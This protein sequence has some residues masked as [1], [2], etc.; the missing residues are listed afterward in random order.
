MCGAG[1]IAI[2]NDETELVV[3]GFLKRQSVFDEPAVQWL[4]HTYAWALENFDAQV[5]YHESVLVEP[6]NRYFPGRA[7]SVPAMAGLVF[8]KV[9]EYAGMAHW[10]WQLLDQATCSLP[11]TGVIPIHGALRGSGGRVSEQTGA[12]I[13][14]AYNP[15]QVGEPDALIATFA[16]GLAQHL[17]TQAGSP[18]PGGV[19]MWPQAT[20][21]LAVFMGF[22]L[23]FANSAFNHRGGCGSCYNSAAQRQANLSEREATY[24][25]AIF[26]VLKDIPNAAVTT[27]L[28]R[29]L[30]SVYKDAVR[31][32]RRRGSEL[33]RLRTAAT[34]ARKT[35]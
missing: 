11:T 16:H 23:M 19:D 27:N 30:R 18:P 33:E 22:G 20:E 9:C 13:P 26:A 1:T 17:G 34:T 28:K 12:R 35:A 8:A 3:F 6:S 31:D 5:F 10:P 7:D 15:Q 4:F 2:R 21:L 24:A 14:V 29:H 32:I 25:L